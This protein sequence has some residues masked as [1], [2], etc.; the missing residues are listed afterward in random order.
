MNSPSTDG[1]AEPEASPG[2][3][4]LTITYEVDGEIIRVVK[5]EVDEKYVW[6]LRGNSSWR[7]W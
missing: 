5:K 3:H 6:V 4:Q 2:N 1:T 7:E